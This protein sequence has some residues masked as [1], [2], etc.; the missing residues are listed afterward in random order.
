MTAPHVKVLG[1]YSPRE[2]SSD[3]QALLDEVVSRYPDE[4]ADLSPEELADIREELEQNL[5]GAVLVE[6]SVEYADETFSM[7]AFVHPD[8]DL[9][10]NNW[11]VAWCEKYLTPDGA[12]PLGEYHFDEVPSEPCFRVVFYIHYWKHE[13]GLNGP[14]GPLELPPIQPMP[15][16]LWQL[17]PYEQVG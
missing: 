15:Q 11:Q 5:G 8:P 12:G 3:F 16:R 4:I 13:N 2:S 14:Y 1:I 10:T 9:P 7:E 6:A 17:A